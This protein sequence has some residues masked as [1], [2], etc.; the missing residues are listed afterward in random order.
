MNKIALLLSLLMSIGVFKTCA[1]ET[2][3]STT[4]G[5][6]TFFSSAPLEDIDARNKHVISML[7]TESL[8]IMVRVPIN[9]F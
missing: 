3:V 5:E 1:Q 2:V 6:I 8:E 9:Q 7:N 4:K